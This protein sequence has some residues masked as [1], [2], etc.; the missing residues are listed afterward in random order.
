MSE[1]ASRAEKIDRVTPELLN[2][3]VLDDRIKTRSDAYAVVREGRR[4][5]IDPLPLVD[6][7]LEQL[8]QVEAICLTGSCH[9]RSAWR[10][11]K[12]FG[13]K[14]HAP[15]GAEGLE[16]QP[17]AWYRKGE[18]PAGDLLAIHAPG[19]AA[20]HYALLLESGGGT[21]FCA[22][23]LYR[24][25]GDLAFVPDQHQ[26]DPRRT[27][28]TARGFLDLRFTT[29]CPSHGAPLTEGTHAAIR[30]TLEADLQRR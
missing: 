26:D 25:D 16:E 22:D 5:L 15:E 13:A 23:I 28:V 17:D 7:A 3:H 2:W 27:R 21:L 6:E 11:R 10:Y 9:Q 19:P 12:R 29:L 30:R 14:V 24:E 18:R 1:P 4:V 8:G 20:A